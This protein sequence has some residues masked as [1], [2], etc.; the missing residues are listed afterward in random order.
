MIKPLSKLWLCSTGI[1]YKKFIAHC[2]RE[3]VN[4][5]RVME[6]LGMKFICKSQGC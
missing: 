5:Y 3:N 1:K 4:S 6:K 2:D